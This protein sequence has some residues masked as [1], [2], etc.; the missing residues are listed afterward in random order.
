[1]M[2]TYQTTRGEVE[3][4]C[5]VDFDNSISLLLTDTFQAPMVKLREINYIGNWRTIRVATPDEAK[6]Y[7]ERHPKLEGK[8]KENL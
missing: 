6:G 8:R 7:F 4:W 5:V 1:M 3:L 2:P